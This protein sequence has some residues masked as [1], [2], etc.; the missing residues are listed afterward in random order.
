MYDWVAPMFRRV[1]VGVLLAI[2]FSLAFWA[3][4]YLLFRG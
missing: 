1:A 2:V 3:G 4:L